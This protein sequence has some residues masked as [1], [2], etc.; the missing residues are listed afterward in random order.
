MAVAEQE[1]LSTVQ[2]SFVEAFTAFFRSVVAQPAVKRIDTSRG[3]M[4]P[5]TWWVFIDP[6][7]DA[8][9]NHI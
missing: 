7:T 1:A 8:V 2:A 4:A 9:L 3:E 6:D 5:A